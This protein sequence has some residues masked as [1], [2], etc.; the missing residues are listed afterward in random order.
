MNLSLFL[1]SL[2]LLLALVRYASYSDLNL[3]T[4]T[5]T[6]SSSP[7]SLDSARIPWT[8]FANFCVSGVGAVEADVDAEEERSAV[9][10]EGRVGRDD[11]SFWSDVQWRSRICWK[12]GQ[13]SML[14]ALM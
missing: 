8:R 13:R 7:A 3:P 11:V 12:R 5:D 14:V 10:V 9:P 2:T 4:E 6:G 1:A